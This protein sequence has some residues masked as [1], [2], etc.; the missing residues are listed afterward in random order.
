M[1]SLSCL[2]LCICFLGSPATAQRS[3][4][5]K[6]SSGSPDKLLAV[7][8]VGTNRYTDSEILGASG[9]ELGRPATD[10]DFKEASRRL[11]DSGLFSEVEYSYSSS[12]NGIKVEFHLID[13]DQSKLV[14]ARF[15]NFVWFTDDELLSALQKRVPLFKKLLPLTGRLPDRV[16]E[17]LQSTLTDKRFP[18]R[19][20][21]LRSAPNQYAPLDS[22]D[23]RVEE[24]T[25]E[26]HAL[27]FPGAA[28]DF[29]PLLSAAAQRA[30]GGAYDRTALAKVAQFDL[31]PV[32]LQRGY[33]RASFGPS[34]ARVLPAADPNS[35]TDIE[36]DAVIPVTT[37]KVYS[38]A[39]FDW[40]G[41]SVVKTDEL[42][43]LLH[44]PTGQPA[45]AVRLMR[46]VQAAEKLYASRGYIMAKI[47]TDTQFDEDKN[48]VHYNFSV[49]EGDLFRMGEL[50]ILGLDTQSTARMRDAWKLHQGSP[51]DG[52][53]LKN[54]IES[55]RDILPRG[56][57]W[58]PNT[59]ETPDVKD[60]IVD[61]EIHFKQQ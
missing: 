23:Y 19:V 39:G 6:P 16:E 21:Y 48:T 5:T 41:N 47:K 50:E 8:A 33:L 9:L 54:F 42:S 2:L 43:P 17:A 53:Y 20:D 31:L 55:T 12:P 25:I 56:V 32:F 45:D 60:K 4:T 22:I 61:V 37:G 29:A 24:V 18:G 52:G 58:V 57:H 46:D 59:H 11:G 49:T 44:L 3:A 7:K 35:P 40:A 1:K 26:I 38:A 27:D 36:V 10:A 28:T 30:I 14:P 34:D 51:Y 15:D 13:I